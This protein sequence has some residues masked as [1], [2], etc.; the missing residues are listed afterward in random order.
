MTTEKK[1]KNYLKGS[2]KQRDFGPDNYIINIDLLLSDLQAK[3]PVNERG[4]VKIS[5]S[6]L[7]E[8]DQYGNTHSIYQNDFVPSTT[9]KKEVAAPVENPAALRKR[10]TDDLPF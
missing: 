10:P 8:P 4:Y 5:I 9:Y 1:K 7:K 2:A 6:K 3:C